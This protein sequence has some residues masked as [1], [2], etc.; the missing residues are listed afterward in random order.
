MEPDQRQYDVALSFAGE[1][2]KYVEAVADELRAAGVKVFYDHFEQATL[3][4]KDL[5]SHLDHVY[6]E[7]SYYCVIFVSRYYREKVW[8]NHERSSA[9]ARA[10][11][12]NR[13][14]VLPVRFDDTELPGLLPTIGYQDAR[15]IGPAELASLVQEKLAAR[16]PRSSDRQA[17]PIDRPVATRSSGTPSVNTVADRESMWAVLLRV[18]ELVEDLVPFCHEQGRE[19]LDQHNAEWVKGT[20]VLR[21]ALAALPRDYLPYCRQ[22]ANPVGR[23]VDEKRTA[24]LAGEEVVMVLEALTNEP[25]LFA[26]SRRLSWGHPPKCLSCK[27]NWGC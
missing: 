1:D 7:S 3:W 17:E 2:R 10:L 9:Q 25:R 8:T 24:A 27:G 12:D 21:Q 22:L 4:G 15:Q 6:R 11:Q 26:F 19:P 14:Y 18:G 20:T 23:R 5:Y 16:L 13:E